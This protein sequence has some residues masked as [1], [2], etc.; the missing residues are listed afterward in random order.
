MSGGV[1]MRQWKPYPAYKDSGVEWLGRVPEGW[2][3]K[4]LKDVG[5]FKGGSGFPNDEQGQSNLE[6]P[7]YKVNALS[8]SSDNGFLTDAQDTISKETAQKLRTNIFPSS[9]IVFA[10][11]GAALLLGRIKFLPCPACLDNNMMGFIID[12]DLVSNSF[13]RYCVEQVQFD[14]IV[15][16][17][18]V[19]SINETKI[20]NYLFV[21]PPLA[22]QQT[23]A[24]F[25]DHECARIDALIAKKRRLLELLEEK[26]RAVITRAVTRGLDPNVPMK[27]SGVEWLGQVP[28]RWEVK[29]LRFLSRINPTRAEMSLPPETLVSFAPMEAVGEYGG[30]QCQEK[31]LDEIGSS[32]T[33]FVDYDVLIA[34]ITPCF[35]NGKGALAE[36]LS[37]GVGFGSTEFHV[38][39]CQFG[40]SP[41][42]FFYF[43]IS[44]LFRKIGEAYMYGAGGQKR[45][46]DGY[47]KNF[48][49]PTPSFQEQ[50]AISEHLDSETAAIDAQRQVY[51]K[52]IAL[53]QEYRASLITHAVTGKIDVR[54]YAPPQ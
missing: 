14:L 48:F 27:D 37:N 53:L 50:Q 13:A 20:A 49:L 3:V 42:F 7:F 45:I 46:P 52:S 1:G 17:G 40:L 11:V 32:Y 4:R 6:L 41:R 22:E 5:L 9:C 8:Q 28:E 36:N 2:E 38:V 26:R 47:V 21:S 16:P 23:I 19:P 54:E 30:M 34:K 35:E 33:Y 39:R 10:K 44:Q 24:S 51:E 31:T 12:N 43:S 29:R 25:L 15:N 18:A